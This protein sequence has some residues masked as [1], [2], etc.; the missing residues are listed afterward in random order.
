MIPDF[1]H[2]AF[3]LARLLEEKRETVTVVLP[4]REV[5]DTLG[6]VVTALRSLDPLV[7]QVLV[8]DAA[9]EDG[10]AEIARVAGAEVRQEA[11]LMPEFGPVLGKGD[12]MWRAL[13][14]AEGELVAYL[15]SDTRGFP[16]HFATGVLGPLICEEG[17]QLVKGS[18]R[19]PLDTGAGEVQ[20]GGGRVTQ[21]MARP[22]LSAFYPELAGFDQPLAGEVAARR[23]LFERMSF[24]TGYAVETRMLLEARDLLPSEAMV[25][26]DLEERRNHHQ[27]LHQLGA[28]SYAVLSTVMDHLRREGRLADDE[29]PPF[30]A[31]DGGLVDL[32]TE[33]RPP[34]ASLRAP[35]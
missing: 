24:G 5:A 8:V 10:S 15:D 16:A 27:P 28:M 11:E 20:D 12:A 19:R 32:V 33:Q 1:H 29:L 9:S 34:M 26:T 2:A 30:R 3:P 18:Y 31:A 35:A 4:A 7:D 6:Q 25:Q 22:L 17:V 23:A 14:V 21:L 13:S